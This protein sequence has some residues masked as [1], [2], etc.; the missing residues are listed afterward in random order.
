MAG[1][2]QKMGSELVFDWPRANPKSSCGGQVK[3]IA[4]FTVAVA[5]AV[6]GAP[7]LVGVAVGVAVLTAA[8]LLAVPVAV[9]VLPGAPVLLGVAVG[10]AVL[11]T[12]VLVAV[13]VAVGV[14]VGVRVGVSVPVFEGVAVGHMPMLTAFGWQRPASLSCT[15]T[16]VVML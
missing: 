16:P 15:S 9:A 1:Y 13:P 5:V 10:V 6:P 12:A 4:V 3:H 14:F 7:V 2:E 11:A 8:V